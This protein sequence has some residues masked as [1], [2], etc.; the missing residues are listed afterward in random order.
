M[1][2][3]KIQTVIIENN[4]ALNSVDL[5]HN[6]ISTIPSFLYGPGADHQPIETVLL[7]DNRISGTL[8][9]EVEWNYYLTTLDLSRNKITGGGQIAFFSP[10][11]RNPARSVH[12]VDDIQTK[13]YVRPPYRR[14]VDFV[15]NNMSVKSVPIIEIADFTRR[16]FVVRC[17]NGGRC[18]VEDLSRRVSTLPQQCG[19]EQ[20]LS[21][22]TLHCEECYSVWIQS[23]SSISVFPGLE[24][25]ARKL[26]L[27]GQELDALVAQARCSRECEGT[28]TSTRSIAEDCTIQHPI[29][30]KVEDCY[31]PCMSFPPFL[32]IWE[33]L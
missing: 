20:F 4:T 24:S 22:L 25:F 19:E 18:D 32:L 30:T 31:L 7:S 11:M 10:L 8:P 12:R 21:K 27:S 5:S 14:Q 3:S 2:V 15:G 23:S 17:P 33:A 13:L 26:V 29:L 1:I 16:G 28:R 6:H 9:D